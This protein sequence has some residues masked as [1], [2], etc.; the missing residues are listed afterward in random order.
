MPSRRISTCGSARRPTKPRIFKGSRLFLF[1]RR[2]IG[3]GVTHLR[4]HFR[5]LRS[6]RTRVKPAIR[7]N[8]NAAP[9]LAQPEEAHGDAMQCEF[10]A[11]FLTVNSWTAWKT[12]AFV[13]G[14]KCY[15]CVREGFDASFARG[16]RDHAARTSQ[17]GRAGRTN[18]RTRANQRSQRTGRPG[19]SGLEAGKEKIEG[20]AQ[21]REK[22]AEKETEE[23][24]RFEQGDR[25]IF[26][27]DRADRRTGAHGHSP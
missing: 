27:H 17:T 19:K 1:W 4:S 18:R 8:T 10:R 7:V 26:P 3:D 22:A 15:Q 13:I 5:G 2:L 16:D 11:R 21:S 25:R 9:R 6:P 14:L 23:E 12:V 24:E 20:R